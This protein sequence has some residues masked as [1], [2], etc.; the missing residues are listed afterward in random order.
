M[1][2]S[3]LSDK[4]LLERKSRLKRQANQLHNSQMAIKIAMN[5]LYG[6]TAN[7]YFL[8]YIAEMAEA[9]T[10]SGQ[11]STRYA[12]MTVNN[13]LNRVL[14]TEDVAYVIY[15]VDGDTSL[16]V[17]GQDVTIKQLYNDASVVDDSGVKSTSNLNYFV[18]SYNKETDKRE[19]KRI[20]KVIKRRAKK[21]MFKVYID[22]EKSI[23]V[24]SD[25]RF[26]VK[27]N[28]QVVEVV[29]EDLREDDTFI[30]IHGYT[31]EGAYQCMKYQTERV[32]I[33]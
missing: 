10:T 8:Y 23:T 16:V 15:C 6:A 32:N 12:E 14:D 19:Y 11:L 30:N 3:T 29:A 27:R 20:T 4:E 26:I 1:N 21:R 22:D 9:I 5:S 2:L 13:Y 7:I 33:V 24:S 31:K 18:M 28:G 17:N 25:H